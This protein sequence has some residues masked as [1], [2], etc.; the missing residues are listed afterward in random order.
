MLG[1]REGGQSLPLLHDQ[2]G[3]EGLCSRVEPSIYDHGV[4]EEYHD[5][6]EIG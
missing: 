1:E 2:I 6:L 3:V 4:G 5:E